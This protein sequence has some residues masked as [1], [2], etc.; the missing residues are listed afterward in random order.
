MRAFITG[1]LRPVVIAAAVAIAIACGL[2]AFGPHWLT[3]TVRV[4]AIYDSAA[5]ALLLSY[6][7][8]I[9]RSDASATRRHAAAEDPGRNL[10]TLLVATGVIFGFV[11]A[12]NILARGPQG[13]PP[14]HDFVILGFGFGA[15]I[16]G[17]FLIHSTVLFRYAHL[18]YRDT[19]GDDEVDGGL[20][21]PG[22]EDPD[23]LD[24]AYFALVIGMTFQ[25]SDVQITARPIRRL[26][27]VHGLVSFGYSTAILAL[28]VN[29]VSGF[30]H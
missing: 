26:A 16:A 27:M 21:F 23:S 4:V 19:D 5:L 20:T 11:S 8:K 28:V 14:H 18:Y 25:V 3:K 10:A 1:A 12:L 15:V 30:L 24:F 9:L 7:S 29:I 6:W 13:Q 17:W 2:A 22:N